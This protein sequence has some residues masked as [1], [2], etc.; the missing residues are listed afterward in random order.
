MKKNT[1]L[2]FCFFTVISGMQAP[3]LSQLDPR[4][5]LSTV[6]PEINSKRLEELANDFQEQKE[7]L[8]SGDPIDVVIPCHPKDK[9][10]LKEV[11]PALKETIHNLR[12]IF[13]ISS[14]K[15]TSL[16]E[17][18]DESKFPFSK[19]GIAKKIFNG[20]E[21]KAKEYLQKP[22]CRIGWIFQQL[23][24]L[25]S[26]FVISNISDNVLIVD[27]DTIF[28]KK[29]DFLDPQTNAGILTAAYEYH[30]PYFDH[31]KKLIP[32]F[33]KITEHSGVAH[34]MLF[35]KQIMLD[36]F[37]VIAFIHKKE[38]WIA[39]CDCIDLEQLPFSSMSEYE[40]Y[41]NF[42][43]AHSDKV[44]FRKLKWKSKEI[45]G[46]LKEEIEQAKAEEVD[47]VS[48]HTWIS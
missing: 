12:N 28:L 45:E 40:I 39:I 9:E 16:A 29:I 27:A 7:Y 3:S 31:A 33:K 19:L 32:G 8:F 24:K 48:L 22:K 5:F 46:D 21:S 10:K 34:H 20:D 26:P 14:K 41:A 11:I 38:P 15:I 13:V 44:N 47:Y 35:Q 17:W 42:A 23:L 4:D 2:L 18:F 43:A 37:R 1:I 6:A 30:K 36:L 25:Y